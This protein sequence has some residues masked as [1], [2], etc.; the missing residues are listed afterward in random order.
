MDCHNNFVTLEPL[1]QDMGMFL[2]SVPG[3]FDNVNPTIGRM[4]TWAQDNNYLAYSRVE[5]H[6]GRWEIYRHTEAWLTGTQI[7]TR[8][9][10]LI[11]G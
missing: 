5:R 3:G 11:G 9:C 1:A 2:A 10:F 8:H 7:C 4:K 6:L